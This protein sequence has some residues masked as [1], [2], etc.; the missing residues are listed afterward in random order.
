VVMDFDE[1]TSRVQAVMKAH[2]HPLVCPKAT[3]APFLILKES[4][5]RKECFKEEF[6]RE[7]DHV[8]AQLSGNSCFPCI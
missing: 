8:H 3:R 4:F 1:R 7:G 2:F 6:P 5:M